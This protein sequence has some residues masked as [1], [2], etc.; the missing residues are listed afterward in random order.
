MSTQ[1]ALGLQDRQY[2]D[3]H[4][5]N[6]PTGITSAAV[7]NYSYMSYFKLQFLLITHL[8]VSLYVGVYAIIAATLMF[9]TLFG[10]K[11]WLIQSSSSLRSCNSSMLDLGLFFFFFISFRQT[12]YPP[13]TILRE[14]L[15]FCSSSWHMPTSYSWKGAAVERA[16]R[17]T[18]GTTS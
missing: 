15:S 2:I 17:L 6:V 9:G 10:T 7:Q 4:Y 13:L 12:V 3:G 14:A 8:I 16:Y 1:K 18:F 11:Y 5:R